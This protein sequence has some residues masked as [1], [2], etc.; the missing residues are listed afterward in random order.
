MKS[1]FWEEQTM[2]SGIS[3]FHE[4][5]MD[6]MQLPY[7]IEDIKCPFCDKELPLRS[8]RNVQLCLNT[9]NF[10]DIAIEVLCDECSK[11]DTLYFREGCEHISDF[12]QKLACF[13]PGRV[14]D[15]LEPREAKSKPVLEKEMYDMKYNNVMEKMATEQTEE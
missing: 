12:T 5:L 1:N 8:I 2:D 7:W 4:K 14:S 10:G 6:K 9:R 15:G 3:D 11:M 13:E